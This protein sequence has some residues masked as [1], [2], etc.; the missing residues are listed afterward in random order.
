M[1]QTEKKPKRLRLDPG[2]TG[3][4]AQNLFH[5]V[6]QYELSADQSQRG[7]VSSVDSGSGSL[8]TDLDPRGPA[9]GQDW[10]LNV[11]ELV[12]VS[13]THTELIK[14]VSAAILNESGSLVLDP[15]DPVQG[16]QEVIAYFETIPNVVPSKPST[17]F[18]SPDTV[19]SSA[20]NSEPISSTLPIVSKHVPTR[21]QEGGGATSELEE[22]E[23]EAQELQ[24]HR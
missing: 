2:Q 15:P 3:S 18:C 19:L 24:E 4:E 14:G 7:D 8:Q 9:E 1:D 6:H 21:Q 20:L 10:G 13:E 12:L 22:A 11:D 5:A 23:Q 16:G 17:R